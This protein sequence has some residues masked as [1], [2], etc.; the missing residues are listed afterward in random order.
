LVALNR[1]GARGEGVNRRAIDRLILIDE[2]GKVTDTIGISSDNPFDY[3]DSVPAKLWYVDA[4]AQLVKIF[5][6]T[7]GIAGIGDHN[8]NGRDEIALMQLAGSIFLPRIYEF[9][10]DTLRL[11]LPDD[12]LGAITLGISAPAPGEFYIYEPD[13]ESETD[14]YR[15]RFHYRWSEERAEYEL[16]DQTRMTT[17]EFEALDLP[18]YSPGTGSE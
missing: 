7:I 3:S 8:Q 18:S 11:V 1:V 4:W 9:H 12:N 6:G 15:V 16:V 5:P 10:D 14:D 2:N 17:E 13:Y